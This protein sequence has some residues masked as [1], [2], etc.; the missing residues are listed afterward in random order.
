MSVC[1]ELVATSIYSQCRLASK[2]RYLQMPIERLDGVLV[3]D[4]ALL[5]LHRECKSPIHV[6]A[7]L[8]VCELIAGETGQVGSQ[9]ECKKHND[10]M[11]LFHKLMFR[12]LDGVLDSAKIMIISK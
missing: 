1:L 8:S 5:F 11:F 2:L 7:H 10:S 9:N 12:C 4:I 3:D 6:L